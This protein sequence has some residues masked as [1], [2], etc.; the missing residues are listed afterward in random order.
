MDF[1]EPERLVSAVTKLDALG[2]QVHFHAIGEAAVRHALDAVEAARR[3]NGWSDL[4]HQIAHVCLVYPHDIPRFAALGVSAN[5]QPYWAVASLDM[6]RES[7][8]LGEPRAQWWYPFESLRRSG[9]HLAGGSDWPVSTANPLDGIHVAVNRELPGDADGAFI[10][11]ER[12]SLDAAL[13]AYTSGS[14]Y[15]NHLDETGDLSVGKLADLIVLDRRSGGEADAT[16]ADARV[17]LTVLDGV[18]VHQGSS[19]V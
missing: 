17:V 12:M 11:T 8:Y 2:F 18:V 7:I 1:I 10:P 13:T 14:A 9:A 4:R 15:T 5:I 6:I 3:V 16:I 19:L